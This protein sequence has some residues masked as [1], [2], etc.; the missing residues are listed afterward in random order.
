M[1][2]LWQAIT[3]DVA[4]LLA[5]LGKKHLAATSLCEV[6]LALLFSTH[7]AIH[8]T[9]RKVT[10]PVTGLAGPVCLVA[11]SLQKSTIRRAPSGSSLI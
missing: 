2:Q 8:S 1:V 5:D 10:G 3:R 6:A 4:L 11:N 7:L 9:F